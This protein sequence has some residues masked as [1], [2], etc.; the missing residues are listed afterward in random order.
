MA[1]ATF[2]LIFL[3]LGSFAGFTIPLSELPKGWYWAS[4]VRTTALHA[5][6]YPDANP[7]H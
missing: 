1:L 2:P 3:F 5:P 7:H 6:S 4:Y